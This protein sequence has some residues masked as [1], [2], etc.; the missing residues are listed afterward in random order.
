MENLLTATNTF[1]FDEDGA[2][3]IYICNYNG[4]HEPQQIDYILS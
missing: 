4:Q 2:I 1:R 3:N